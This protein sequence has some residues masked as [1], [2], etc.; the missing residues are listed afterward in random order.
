MKGGRVYFVD[1]L[2]S[3]KELTSIQSSVDKFTPLRSPGVGN[4]YYNTLLDVNHYSSFLK[5]IEEYYLSVSRKY[6]VEIDGLW[7]NKVTTTSNTSDV[8]HVDSSELS[9]VTLLN[10][11]YEGGH[12]NYTN[13][14]EEDIQLKGKKYTTLIFNGKLTKHR[15][16]PVT[17]G[18]RWS[19]VT[20]WQTKIKTT[21]TLL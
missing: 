10:D 13:E 4:Y 20:F 17:K 6:L 8:F 7:I 1:N 2:L 3:E 5:N 21:K 11:D 16:L 12:F 19:L 9:T 18:V 15:V 14:E